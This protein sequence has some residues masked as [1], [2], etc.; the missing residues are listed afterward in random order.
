MEST[1]YEAVADLI[2]KW[3]P[4]E[5]YRLRTHAERYSLEAV[6]E[7]G[8]RIIGWISYKIKECNPDVLA[9]YEDSAEEWL[10]VVEVYTSPAERRHGVGRALMRHVEAEGKA[11]GVRHSVLMPEADG[12]TPSGIAQDLMEFYGALGYELMTPSPKHHGAANPWLMG[13]EL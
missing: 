12:S 10:Y 7:H 5:I 11:A 9:E 6:A 8:G 1:D 2:G 3:R 13:L 4:R